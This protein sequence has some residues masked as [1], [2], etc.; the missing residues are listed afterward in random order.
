MHIGVLTLHI[1]IEE[2]ASLKEKR[3]AIH[4]LLGR[5]RSRFPVS[6]AEVDDLDLWR[7]AVL[8]AAM[9]SNDAALC[10]KVLEKVADFVEGDGRVVLE[11]YAIEML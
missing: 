5:I 2:A 4:S 10:H 7:H 9:V 1:A 11:D 8:G 3:H 6:I